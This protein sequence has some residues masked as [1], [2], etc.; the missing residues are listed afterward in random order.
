LG[1]FGPATVA[2]NVET[3]YQNLRELIVGYQENEGKDDKFWSKVN[4]AEVVFTP[5]YDV[6]AL[7]A[8]H[9]YLNVSKIAEK[10]EINP[11]LMRQYSSGVK[12]PRPD[13]A[14]KIEDAIHAVGKELQQ[15][16]VY[17]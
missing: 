14:K 5:V 1:E 13:Q 17:A 16:A 10:A 6:Q 7:F 12:H 4:A 9:N 3:V 15:V 2:D 8:K 11:G